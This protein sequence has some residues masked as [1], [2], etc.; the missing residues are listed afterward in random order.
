M[1]LATSRSSPSRSSVSTTITVRPTCSGTVV[2]LTQL[3][4]GTTVLDGV[5][6]TLNLPACGWIDS[7]HVFA[8]GDAQ[9]QPRVGNIIN[10]AVVHVAAQGAC[11]GRLPG[12]L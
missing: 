7:T 11:A 12:G 6:R 5:G 1:V 4:T 3:S 2:A 9:Q 10:G 8:G